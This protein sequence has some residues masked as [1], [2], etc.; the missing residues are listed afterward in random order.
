MNAL[1]LRDLADMTRRGMIASGL[2]GAIPGG[3]T[4][5]YDLD[6]RLD[7]RQELIKG[8]RRI[9]PQQADTVRWI[10]ARY[11]TGATLHKICIDLNRQ[12]ISAPKGGPWVRT[13]LIGQVARKTGLLR[14]TL[15][16]GVVTFN[17]LMY[18]KNPDTGKRQSF[19]RPESDWIQVPVPELAILDEKLFDQ[20]QVMIEERSNLY[21]QRQ[22][23]NRVLPAPDKL[24]KARTRERQAAKRKGKT[25]TS[26]LYIFSGKLWCA[27]HHTAISVIRKRVY[28]CSQKVCRQRNVKHKV[29]MQAAL[30]ATSRMTAEQIRAAL[31]K[32][33]HIRDELEVKINAL[34]ANL[35]RARQDIRNLLDLLAKRPVTMETSE[36]LDD[37]EAK[38]LKIKY[39][40]DKLKKQHAPVAMLPDEEMDALLKRFHDA[41][42]PLRHD[43]ADQAATAK[44]YAWFSRFAIKA[45]GDAVTIDITYDWP[46][47]LKAL[48]KQKSEPFL[49][50][51]P[52]VILHHT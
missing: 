23:L 13:T 18:R 38:I 16:K 12:G 44:V 4:Y 9:N 1:H 24:T 6:H 33:R 5:G 39:E 26:C 45:D 52:A 17:R 11:A 46:V 49:S 21:K 35:D 29:F 8:L 41:I 7:D 51:R 15:Y 10:F 20:I 37:R 47:L 48:R 42:A 28:N 19:I 14:Q 2:K 22:L 43:D 25:R 50:H 36:Y 34:E 27:Q 32:Q 3:R 31:S 30:K 40:I